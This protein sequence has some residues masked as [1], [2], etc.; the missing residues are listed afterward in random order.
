VIARDFSIVVVGTGIAGVSAVA[1]MRAAGFDGSVLMVG[2]EPQL[3]YRR[4]TVS[5]ELVRGAKTADQVRIKPESWYADHDVELLTGLRVTDLDPG[6]RCVGFEDG[7]TT[8]YTQLLLATGG[9]ARNPWPGERVH[10][11]RTVADASQ[12]TSAVADV[13][14]VLVVGA[15]LVGSEIA[16]SLRA[17]DRDVTLL[18]SAPLPLPRLLP[19][20][21]SRRYVDLH[22]GSGTKLETDVAV[23]AI[24]ERADAVRV[25]AADGRH[26]E[27]DL[28]VV[29]IGMEPDLALADDLVTDGGIVVDWRGETSVRGVFAAGDVAARPSSF[30]PGRMRAEHW[31]SAQNHGTAVGRAMTGEDVTFDEV[32]WSWS[33]QYGVNLQVTGWPDP[34]DHLVVRGDLEGETFTA[35]TLRDGVLRGAVT[36]G[37]PADVRAARKLI[38]ARARVDAARLSDPALGVDETVVA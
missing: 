1:A 31:Q 3:P 15:G 33:D 16:A 38:A 30:L 17:L 29:A 8:G 32:P 25:S 23:T 24:S 20:E 37:R 26:W 6:N 36:V 35:F 2:D 13:D 11:L 10:T 4:P 28:V 21:L 34:T 22:A 5:K 14:H 9:R 19:P 27:A 12:L 7:S 18:E